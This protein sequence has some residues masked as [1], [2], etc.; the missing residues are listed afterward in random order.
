MKPN[1][2]I[3]PATTITQSHRGKNN[4]TTAPT[5]NAIKNN[6]MVFLKAP[7]KH[8]NLS[9]LDFTLS[10]MYNILCKT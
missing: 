7:N 5:P 4:A 6:P 3:I 9:P 1:I 2:I 8:L 10:L